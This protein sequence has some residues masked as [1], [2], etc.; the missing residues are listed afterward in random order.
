MTFATA[1]HVDHGKSALVEALTGVHPDRLAEEQ[2]RGMTLDLGFGHWRGADGI[3]RSIVDVPGHERFIHTMLAGAGGVDAV[4]LVVAADAGVQPQT[5]EHF[6]ICRLLGLQR[7]AVALTKCDL[8]S[9]EQRAAVR[10]QVSSLVA[11]SF[12]AEAP[13][14]AVSSKTGEGLAALRGALEALPAAARDAGA[15]FRLPVDRAFAMPGFGAVVTGTLL[16]GTIRPGAEAVLEPGGQRARVRGVQ[17]H[18]AAVAAARAG[19]R[20]A[21]N[22]AGIEVAALHRGQVLCEPEVFRATAQWDVALEALPGVDLRARER[23]QVH[24]HAASAFA[25]LNWIE[26]PQ[27]AQLRLESPLCA[28][29]GDRFILRR[30]SPPETLGGGRVLEPDAPRHRLAER[31]EAARHLAA[32]RVADVRAGLRLRLERAGTVGAG[33]AA[34]AAAAGLRSAQLQSELAAAGA[35]VS[36]GMAISGSALA[37]LEQ[38]LLAG[39]APARFAPRWQKLAAQRLRAAGR[40]PAAPEPDAAAITLRT[41]IEARF[42]E[43]GLAAPPLTEFLAAF[44]QPAARGAVAALARERR[45]VECQPG[46]YLHAEAIAALKGELSRRRAAS[47]R[48][49]VGEF[50]QWTGLTRKSAIPLLEYLDRQRLTRRHGD[51][52]EIV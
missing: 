8:G 32:L 24:L 47:P 40:I 33:L 52:R 39:A 28:A 10:G 30:L 3:E 49:S 15:P 13:L 14:L 48:F 27:Y 46:W 1:G 42:R 26:A 29:A 5:A 9:A 6:Q 4:L 41:A 23:L 31:A 18:G 25:T 38:A 22:L 35:H 21:V 11:G 45:L 7:G 2:R 37:S 51:Q 50:K 20:T 17:V 19:E 44:P 16:A 34:L 36:E 12:L 43:L